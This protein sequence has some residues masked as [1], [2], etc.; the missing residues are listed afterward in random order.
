MAESRK[1][2]TEKGEQ[3][4]VVQSA[5]HSTRKNIFDKLHEEARTKVEIKQLNEEIR[6][7]REIQYCTFRP[8]VTGEGAG[9][10]S[11]KDVYDRLTQT[12]KIQKVMYYDAQRQARETQ[13]CTRGFIFG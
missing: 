12:N 7:R 9:P 11:K 5:R 2:N 10:E 13:Y 6:K 4:F 8:G 1:Q 3:E